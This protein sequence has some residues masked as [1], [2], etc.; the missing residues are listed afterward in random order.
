MIVINRYLHYC[1]FRLSKESVLV[2]ELRHEPKHLGG[3]RC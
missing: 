1:G 2:N 3:M